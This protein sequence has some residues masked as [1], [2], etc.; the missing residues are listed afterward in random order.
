[1]AKANSVLRVYSDLENAE[2]TTCSN[3]K[4]HD[5]Y[6]EI[7]EINM[8]NSCDLATLEHVQKMYDEAV[9]YKMNDSLQEENFA[10]Y[11]KKVQELVSRG[12]SADKIEVFDYKNYQTQKA[13]LNRELLKQDFEE[14]I[15]KS[16][17]TYASACRAMDDLGYQMVRADAT[18]EDESKTGEAR[19]NH[20]LAHEAIFAIPGCNDVVF[21]V[22][23]TG[24]GLRRRL[25]GIQKP[26]GW[27]TS[28]ERIREVA[29]IIE[30]SGEIQRYFGAYIEIG[31]G[32]HG[33][34]EAVDSD[35]ENC[36]AEITA[37]D[38]YVIEN[39]EESN[40]FN[41]I[42]AKAS[43]QEKQ[44]WATKI[45]VQTVQAQSSYREAPERSCV[46]RMRAETG[47]KLREK[48]K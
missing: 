7:Q 15:K 19:E 14:S 23:T 21:Q 36:D 25:I 48:R 11:K 39:E 13:R 10:D 34:T 46:D 4:I 18:M 5:V 8:S 22:V 37:M 45:S 9:Q 2:F 47:R 24:N 12:Y 40:Y 20:G 38:L 43:V 29:R 35:T 3:Q 17:I 32:E 44:K 30:E 16:Y 41:D 31:G 33:V 6:T 28:N 42:V 26:D 27:T 1:M